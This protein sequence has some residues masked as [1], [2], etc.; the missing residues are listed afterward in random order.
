MEDA[1]HEYRGFFIGTL[2][3]AGLICGAAEAPLPAA[4]YERVVPATLQ[5]GLA[6]PFADLVGPAALEATLVGQTDVVAIPETYPRMVL[7]FAAP[8]TPVGLNR[9]I[10]RM[11]DAA[12]TRDTRAIA[13]A[14]LPDFFLERDY[15]GYSELGS[16]QR[17]LL[18]VVGLDGE[19]S[20]TATDTAWRGLEVRITDHGLRRHPARAATYC[21]GAQPVSLPSILNISADHADGDQSIGPDWYRVWGR[22]DLRA[23]PHSNAPVVGSVENEIVLALPDADFD[24]T[25]ATAGWTQIRTPAGEAAFIETALLQGDH[26]D[27]LCFAQSSDGTWGIAGY[28]GGAIETMHTHGNATEDGD[29][30]TGKVRLW[31]G[32]LCLSAILSC[33]PAVAQV[34]QHL[35]LSG[36][37]DEFVLTFEGKA[38]SIVEAWPAG[39]SAVPTGIV[40]HMTGY[41]A[42]AAILGELPWIHYG[43]WAGVM[44][45]D[46]SDPA[47]TLFFDA[48]SGGAHCCSLLAAVT[49]V[50][51]SHLAV[52]QFPPAEGELRAEFPRDIDGDGI[53]DIVRKGEHL[54]DDAGECSTRIAIYNIHRGRHVDVSQLSKFRPMVNAWH[55]RLD[56]A[57]KE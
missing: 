31:L 39:V 25:P 1:L 46:S 33:Q 57:G 32:F 27:R 6:L 53:A 28:I 52:V 18:A 45:L 23:S 29:K 38:I 42:A 12:A 55:R 26:D 17:I 10:R 54:C 49:P 20:K 30:A 11:L 36:N 16:P 2:I 3:S 41:P 21:T 14:V 44:R 13:D 22:H 4:G 43:Q 5:S 19:R 56:E 37:G 35:D 15:A 34:G 48:Y 50:G 24:W 7:E 9:L 47:P 40:V 8:G 51:D